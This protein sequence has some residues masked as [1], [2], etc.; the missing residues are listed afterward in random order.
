MLPVCRRVCCTEHSLVQITDIEILT[1]QQGNIFAAVEDIICQTAEQ[2]A[3]DFIGI[4][5]RKQREAAA[6]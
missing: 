4:E 1:D 2:I 6:F 5:N 3:V